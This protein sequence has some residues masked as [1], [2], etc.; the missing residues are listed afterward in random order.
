M[1]QCTRTADGRVAKPYEQRRV[2]VTKDN[3][4]ED[5]NNELVSPYDNLEFVEEEEIPM[6]EDVENSTMEIEP[7]ELK[8]RTQWIVYLPEMPMITWEKQSQ[9][10]LEES[11]IYKVLRPAGLALTEGVKALLRPWDV[12]TS[13]L[14]SWRDLCNLTL[15]LGYFGQ[16]TKA[17][18]RTGKLA[19]VIRRMAM[20]KV[21]V[22][23]HYVR[24]ARSQ[25]KELA[26]EIVFRD[27][28]FKVAQDPDSGLQLRA[29]NSVKDAVRLT[30]S[31]K[32]NGRVKL[33]P[34]TRFQNLYNP[35]YQHVIYP[36]NCELE[37]LSEVV[38]LPGMAQHL[39][40]TW[41]YDSRNGVLEQVGFLPAAKVRMVKEPNKI[42]L[43]GHL[44]WS[45][46][47]LAGYCPSKLP[48]LYGEGGNVFLN[49]NA[50]LISISQ[51]DEREYQLLLERHDWSEFTWTSDARPTTAMSWTSTVSTLVQ[52]PRRRHRVVPFECSYHNTLA[53]YTV[54]GGEAKVRIMKQQGGCIITG[55]ECGD[56][57][58]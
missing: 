47:G 45:T 12:V 1:F 54:N 43:F 8:G 16:S 13:Y 10:G 9:Y 42:F 53:C 2:R 7:V 14:T 18:W 44:H 40:T 22:Q 19:P 32:D 5:D 29:V 17:N 30:L 35:S 28:K 37:L 31:L 23:Q 52:E 11:P 34:A 4:D 46:R 41:T 27:G 24:T 25:F 20:R 39:D 3:D 57:T 15:A 55:V 21:K 50:V 56:Q 36:E 49:A 38:S 58:E 26:M 48:E 6:E 51:L 33:D